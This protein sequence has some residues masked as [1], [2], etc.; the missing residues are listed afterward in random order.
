MGQLIRF[1]ALALA[2]LL[3]ALVA[4]CSGPVR[5]RVLDWHHEPL[6]ELEPSGLPAPIADA[7]DAWQIECAAD[8]TGRVP[9]LVHLLPDALLELHPSRVGR[10]D[11]LARC[12]WVVVTTPT[13]ATHE[14][15]HVLLGM[16]HSA[17]PSNV[18]YDRLR[19]DTGR[20][21]EIRLDQ[22]DSAAHAA[23]EISTCL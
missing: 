4:G 14:L 23:G 13:S 3:L 20:D 2:L 9:V 10:T 15:G 12:S 18:M 7:C 17:D 1:A 5:L 19:R 16:E 11:R 22:L 6:A 21:D 8:D